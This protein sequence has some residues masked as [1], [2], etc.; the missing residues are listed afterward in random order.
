MNDVTYKKNYVT[1]EEYNKRIFTIINIS[2]LNPKKTN[3]MDSGKVLLGVLAGVAIGATLGILFAPDKG[4]NT[5]R[6][7]SK[8]GSDYAEELETQ[9][10]DFVDSMSNKF[11]SVKEEAKHINE[12]GIAKIE[13]VLEGSAS[14]V[15][16]M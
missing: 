7:I 8:K 12:N 14:Y 1:D 15:K 11:K 10:S 4:V 13:D 9:F 5:R 16:N 6:K 2:I 3:I